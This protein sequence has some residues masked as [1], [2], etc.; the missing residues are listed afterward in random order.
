MHVHEIKD[1]W[2]NYRIELDMTN[3]CLSELYGIRVVLLGRS[4]EYAI[5]GAVVGIL[6]LIV[7]VT[8]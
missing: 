3:V 6:L 7:G 2:R 4:V 5:L 8:L 1:L